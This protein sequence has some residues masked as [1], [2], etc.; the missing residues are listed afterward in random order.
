MH[1]LGRNYRPDEKITT[2]PFWDAAFEV[3]FNSSF[4]SHINKL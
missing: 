3:C 2:K 4:H 1:D